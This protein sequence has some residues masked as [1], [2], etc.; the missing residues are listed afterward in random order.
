MKSSDIALRF[1]ER[2]NAHDVE[3]LTALMTD[4]HAFIDSMGTKFLR[5]GIEGGWR[6]YFEMVPDYWIRIDRAFSEGD[7]ATLIGAAGGTYIPKGGKAAPESRWEAP[8]AWVARVDGAKVA[9]WRIYS[10]NEPIRE[11]M[12]KSGALTR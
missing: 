3:G 2:I 8:A 1:V 7:T 12:R 11:K 10:D 5:P 6:D 4:H 9:E